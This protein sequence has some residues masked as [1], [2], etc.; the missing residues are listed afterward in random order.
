VHFRKAKLKVL[1]CNDSRV[2]QAF[3]VISDKKLLHL[4]RILMLALV[5]ASITK[6]QAP[7]SKIFGSVC[8]TGK[9][10]LVSFKECKTF[11]KF[12]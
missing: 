10:N 2:T 9:L 1:L 6:T 5:F 4:N 3:F 11:E 8:F 12:S 7:T